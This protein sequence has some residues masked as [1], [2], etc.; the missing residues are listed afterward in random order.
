MTSVSGEV[1]E[2]GEV[3]WGYCPNST[4]GAQSLGRE[5]SGLLIISSFALRKAP[6]YV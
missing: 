4:Y 3:V 5:V 1:G 2:V 6:E